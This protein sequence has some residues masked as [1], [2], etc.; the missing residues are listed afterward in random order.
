MN[1]TIYEEILEEGTAYERKQAQ[2]IFEQACIGEKTLVFEE[3]K[4][5]II[6]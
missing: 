6:K 2:I 1:T 4:G 3:G 5:L